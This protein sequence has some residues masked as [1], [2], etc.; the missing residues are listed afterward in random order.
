M[1][2]CVAD[3]QLVLMVM[4]MV[5]THKMYAFSNYKVVCV[6][7]PRAQSLFVNAKKA[8]AKK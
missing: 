1:A 3:S 4:V 5:M 7:I 2:F 6:L 8:F